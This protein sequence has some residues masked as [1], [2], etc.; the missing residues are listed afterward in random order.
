MFRFIAARHKSLELLDFVSQLLPPKPS[1]AKLHH[2][3]ISELM[4]RVSADIREGQYYVSGRLTPDIYDD[5][6]FFDG[7]DPDMP[8]R[9]L[10]RYTDALR[11]L[12]E[13]SSSRI[14]L[15]SMEQDGPSS[16]VARWRLSGKL[17]LPWRPPIKP[18]EG[19]TRYELGPTGLIAAHTET[20]S[21]SA[22]DAFASTL[23][24]GFTL[25]APPAPE[26]DVMRAQ[27]EAGAL[28]PPPP[29]LNED[30]SARAVCPVPHW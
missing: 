23:F 20:W 25:G 29:R 5:A 22:F 1:A 4:D 6:C 30:G 12:F 2:L 19:A 24:P 16:F 10:S 14:E 26:L 17:K 3:P 7:P 18:Y 21:I 15:I 28:E 27:H 9:S 11:G 8:V 13:P